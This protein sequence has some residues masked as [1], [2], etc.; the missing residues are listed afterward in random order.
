MIVVVATS[1]HQTNLQ[2]HQI[3]PCTITLH[4]SNN[5]LCDNNNNVISYKLNSIIC[6]SDDS[7]VILLKLDSIVSDSDENNIILYKLDDS[8]VGDGYNIFMV[9]I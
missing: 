2:C 5:K 9:V 8:S 7:N 3:Y 1:N 4:T 6:D